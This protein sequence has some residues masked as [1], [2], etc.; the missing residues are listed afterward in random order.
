MT[1]KSG[2][3]DNQC[4]TKSEVDT[5]ATAA[6]CT[7]T[8]ANNPS[9][10]ELVQVAS[11][12]ANQ[13]TPTNYTM[14]F[15]T[16]V[17][18]VNDLHWVE[19]YYVELTESDLQTTWGASSAI[20]TLISDVRA[21]FDSL[22]SSVIL[23]KDFYFEDSQGNTS[24]DGAFDN[25]P[26]S[27]FFV[28]DSHVAYFDIRYRSVK[29]TVTIN[30]NDITGRLSMHIISKHP[31]NEFEQYG[32]TEWYVSGQIGGLPEVEGIK[33][34]VRGTAYE[35]YSFGYDYERYASYDS[36]SSYAAWDFE[37][38]DGPVPYDGLNMNESYVPEWGGSGADLSPRDGKTWYL[39]ICGIDFSHLPSNVTVTQTGTYSYRIE[40]SDTIYNLTIPSPTTYIDVDD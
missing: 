31:A 15:S 25:M 5:Q 34:Q 18:C 7:V 14:H 19:E 32:E 8:Y 38:L 26:L 20:A 2:D 3:A 16:N 39:Q 22:L 6:N 28:N 37:P 9:N 23:N 21:S 1:K 27:S 40:T 13:I 35:H 10:N 17:D 11:I 30:S 33:I 29:P 24:I 4:P 36:N 12:T